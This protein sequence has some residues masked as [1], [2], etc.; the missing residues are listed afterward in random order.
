MFI[1][2]CY[3]IPQDKRRTQI[4]KTLE[5]FGRRVQYSVFECD[6]KPAQLQR[7]RE[8]LEAI[9]EP[10]EDDLRFYFLCEAC[11][12]RMKRLGNPRRPLRQN[13]YIL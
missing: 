12:P 7:L 11:V 3:D 5:G 10:S 1:L 6:L 13:I 2:V 4:A 8:K 9:I